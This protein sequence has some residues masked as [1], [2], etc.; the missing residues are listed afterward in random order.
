M[1]HLSLKNLHKTYPSGVKAL[2]Q[3]SL[4]IPNGMFGL[5]GP[6]GAGK[7]TLIR[8]IAALQQPDAGS[9]TF[10]GMDILKEPRHIRKQVA[11]TFSSTGCCG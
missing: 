10:N 9:I 4:E 6:N 3:V 7:S 8:T 11:A 2:H 5:L 1:N